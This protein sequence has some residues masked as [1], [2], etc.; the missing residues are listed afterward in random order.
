MEEFNFISN[1]NT[2]TK[3]EIYHAKKIADNS[4]AITMINSSGEW[5][6]TKK[7]IE[8]GIRN[9]DFVIAQ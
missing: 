9:K 3:G 1:V 7:Q 4:Y 6:M 2:I 8:K 5:N